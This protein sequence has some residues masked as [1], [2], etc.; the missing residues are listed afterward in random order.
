MNVLNLK[1]YILWEKTSNT[2][3]RRPTSTLSILMS[4]RGVGCI[5]DHVPIHGRGDH[6]KMEMEGK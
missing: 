6:I 3:V 4:Y 5:N 2:W 1:P